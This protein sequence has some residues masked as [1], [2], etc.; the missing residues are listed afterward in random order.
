M[1]VEKLQTLFDSRFQNDDE[2][3]TVGTLSTGLGVFEMVMSKF[4]SVWN[5]N[6]ND[7]HNAVWAHSLVLNPWKML[8]C[9]H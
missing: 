6:Y 4:E 1:V 3:I 5:T 8:L 7:S 9:K 2:P